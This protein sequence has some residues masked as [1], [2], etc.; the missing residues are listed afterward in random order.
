MDKK[1]IRG[2]SLGLAFIVGALLFLLIPVRGISWLHFFYILTPL[3][4]ALVVARLLE[5]GTR[6]TLVGVI[7]SLIGYIILIKVIGVG[8]IGVVLV[9]FGYGLINS[10]Y[11]A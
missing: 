7:F 4:S 6:K 11:K 2:F 8:A 1:L 5:T 10:S 9:F 3:L